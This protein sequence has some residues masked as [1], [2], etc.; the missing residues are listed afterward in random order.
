MQ[1]L[2][3]FILQIVGS[4]QNFVPCVST[5]SYLFKHKHA[6]IPL[7]RGAHLLKEIDNFQSVAVV[8]LVG[9]QN[10]HRK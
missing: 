6:I 9:K 4:L 5:L 8:F 1:P 3:L 10:G 2:K 7:R